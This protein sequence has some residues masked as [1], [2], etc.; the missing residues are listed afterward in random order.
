MKLFL[1]L[2][3]PALALT[4]AAAPQLQQ[5]PAS[6]AESQMKAWNSRVRAK[7]NIP[8]AKPAEKTNPRRTAQQAQAP[9]PVHSFEGVEDYSLLM[10]P[11]GSYYFYTAELKHDKVEH[12]YWTEYILTEFT[13]HFYDSQY[14][15]IGDV[16]DRVQYSE[17]EVR[18]ASQQIAAQLT[19]KFFNYDDRLEILLTQIYNTD[20][21][22]NNHTVTRIYSIGGDTDAEGNTEL[23]ATINGMPVDGINAAVDQWSESFY[24]TF[25]HD[26]YT[27]D[28]EEDLMA[29]LE[30][31]EMVLE[32][33]KKGGYSGGPQLVA[34]NRIPVLMMPGDQANTPCLLSFARNGRA[35]FAIQRYEKRFLEEPIGFT[36]NDNPTADNRLLIDLYSIGG[37]DSEF[38]LEQHTEIETLQ[39]QDVPGLLFSYWAIGDLDYERDILMD[40]EGLRYVVAKEKFFIQDDDATLNSYYIYDAQ[41]QPLQTIITDT[42]GYM[43]LTDLPGHETQFMFISTGED[44]A[45]YEMIDLPSGNY[46]T[47]FDALL[48]GHVLMVSGDRVA[49]DTGYVYAFRDGRPTDDGQG[50]NIE[51]VVWLDT[52]A[53]ILRVDRINTGQNI[54]MALG[55]LNSAVLSPYF[56]N[57]DDSQ[58]YMY[59][60][61]R[62]D[63]GDTSTHTAEELLV[64]P[65]GE[66]FAPLLW[67]RPD[68][69]KGSLR[70]I[71]VDHTAS[72][73]V[74][75][76]TYQNEALGNYNVDIYNLPLN[77]MQGQGTADDPYLIATA[78][79]LQQLGLNP[80]AHY[81]L[82]NDINAAGAAFR[83]VQNAFTGTLDG[84]G[85]TVSNLAIYADS[86]YQGIFCQLGQGAQVKDINF[87]NASLNINGV[88]AAGL[89]AGMAQN[90]TISGIHINGLK[91]TGQG[92]FGSIVGSA[93]MT[94][95]IEACSV[96][97]A[98][99][100]LPES[101][102][103]G[104]IA[105]QVR[106]G[107]T[108][109]ACAFTGSINAGQEVGGIVGNSATGDEVVSQCHVNADL[110][111][112]H[113]VGG[114]Y[115]FSNRSTAERCL[116][117][118]AVRTLGDNNPYRDGGPKAGGIVGYLAPRFGSKTDEN[119]N[120]IEPHNTIDHCL[121]ALTELTG[122]EPH[123]PSQFDNQQTTMHRIVGHTSKNETPEIVDWDE[124]GNPIYGSAMTGENYIK[125]NYAL[126]SLPMVSNN[127]GN[128]ETTVEGKSIDA[129]DVSDQWLA[130][131]LGFT[132]GNTAAQPWL[133][134]QHVQAT[135][136]HESSLMLATPA[137]TTTAG[138]EFRV[139][140][141]AGGRTPLTQDQIDECLTKV[142]AVNP[143][144]VTWD[145]VWEYDGTV[146]SFVFNA[147]AEGN[148]T[149]SVCG[150]TVPVTVLPNPT[151]KVCMETLA[152]NSLSLRAGVLTAQGCTVEVYSLTGVKMAEGSNALKVPSLPAGVYAA[153]ATANDGSRS[154]LKFYVK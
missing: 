87:A 53:Q 48:D 105:G 78:G 131:T 115:G 72:P 110:T 102:A 147:M 145:G 153:V 134:G 69:Q 139:R 43:R 20:T 57:T 89:V 79:D 22:G 112:Q 36:D 54:A 39:E 2:C 97:G 111:A 19:A 151:D 92:G 28:L 21:P 96:T 7:A 5:R 34:T 80:S 133:E 45:T 61:K 123:H 35:Y 3:L 26:E 117:E 58:E 106:T 126:S 95:A 88:T 71:F 27:V 114:V 98:R 12:E 119:G 86:G 32:T 10:A 75:Q 1:P 101:D 8:F 146:L 107:V 6:P 13:Y 66:Q 93:S 42:N 140:V 25:T 148:T 64:L 121:V 116:V 59:L 122:H 50:N 125:N 55:Y 17:G 67:L 68:D 40:A 132:Y 76:V 83:P 128:R 91:V 38:R 136:W 30:G 113:T 104:G 37:W 152:D 100:D 60:V 73:A 31:Y 62:Y 144:L 141:A 84:A 49:S 56:Y 85:H 94:T 77:A 99:I 51:K 108:I 118:G 47:A 138:F 74:M 16:H 142:E 149:V 150:F 46:I 130:E 33:Y 120:P 109:T 137:V 9:Q 14:N 81:R 143:D 103:V 41:G 65:A 44:Y 129:A 4:A 135:L 11:D 23:I 52:E 82:T 154:T 29:Y 127:F 63:Q 124:D 70:N 90:A 15:H 24:L 18:I